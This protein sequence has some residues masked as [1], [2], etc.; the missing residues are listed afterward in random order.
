M[1][2]NFNLGLSLI[3]TKTEIETKK[4]FMNCPILTRYNIQLEKRF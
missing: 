1:E 4:E 2:Q 3:L